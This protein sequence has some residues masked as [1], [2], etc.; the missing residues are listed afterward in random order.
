MKIFSPLTNWLNKSLKN[1]LLITTSLLILF[2]LLIQVILVFYISQKS[3]IQIIS[4]LNKVTAEQTALNL[5]GQLQNLKEDVDR[6]ALHI[7]D[8]CEKPEHFIQTMLDFLSADEDGVYGIYLYSDQGVQYYIDQNLLSQLKEVNVEEILAQ[9][10]IQPSPDVYFSYESA[11]KGEPQFI[12][13]DFSDSPRTPLISYS[14]PVF[15]ESGQQIYVLVVEFRINEIERV[16]KEIRVGENGMGYLIDQ[17]G[18]V[19]IHPDSDCVGKNI[20]ENLQP[21]F[22]SSDQIS[23]IVDPWTNFSKLAAYSPVEN[24]LGWVV[25]VEQPWLEAYSPVLE[26]ANISLIILFAALAILLLF[27]TQVEKYFSKPIKNLVSLTQEITKTGDLSKKLNVIRND[28][29]GQLASNFNQM[30]DSIQEIR[31]N[32]K[33]SEEKYRNIFENLPI[34]LWEE[35]FSDIKKYLDELTQKGVK[36]LQT[37]LKEHLDEAIFCASLVKVLNVNKATMYVYNIPY[38][39]ILTMELSEIFSDMDINVFIEEISSFYEGQTHFQSES[40][41][42]RSDGQILNALIDVVIPPGYEE[43][44]ERILVSI[45]DFTSR[46][47]A[48]ERLQES[49]T[50]YQNIFDYSPISLWEEDFSDIK[51]Y[52]NEL[53]EKGVKDLN[54]YFEKNPDEILYCA[55]LVKI[56]DVNQHSADL[57][58]MSRDELINSGFIGSLDEKSA[59]F[60]MDEILYFYGGGKLYRGET[61]FVTTEGEHNISITSVVLLPGSEDTWQKV[62]V[63]VQDI[64]DRRKMELSLRENEERFRSVVTSANDGIAIINENKE[65]IYWNPAAKAI[66]GFAREEANLK[67]FSKFMEEQKVLGVGNNLAQKRVNKIF[68]A[69]GEKKNG[70]PYLLELSINSWI[71]NEREYY[72]VVFRDIT[73]RKQQEDEK[74]TIQQISDLLLEAD[75]METVYKQFCVILV[76]RFQ[77]CFVSIELYD[78]IKNRFIS[79]ASESQLDD[80]SGLTSLPACVEML[81]EVSRTAN[82]LSITTTS[83]SCKKILDTYKVQKILLLPLQVRGHFL[84]VF[85]L[86]ISNLTHQESRLISMLRVL[87]NYLAQEIERKSAEEKLLASQKMA[88]LG[89][90]SAGIAH[91]MNSPLQIVTGLSDSISRKIKSGKLEEE[92]MLEYVENINQNAWRIAGIVRSLLTY[93]HTSDEKKIPENL[94]EIIQDTLLLIEH[95]VN[96]WDNV[97]IITDLHKNLPLFDLDRSGITQVLINLLMNARDAMPQGGVITISSDYDFKQ[98]VLILMIADTGMGISDA[99]QEKIFMPFFTTKPIGKGTGLGLSI[100]HGIIESHGGEIKVESRKGEGTTFTMIFHRNSQD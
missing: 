13:G 94:N 64:T 49:E 95:Q 28:E 72:S 84:G 57:L 48:E 76:E 83:K 40:A 44:W 24:E 89:T 7:Q 14:S 62:L 98:D 86:G 17:N 58:K 54:A 93:A 63:A 36:D 87:A 59:R 97:R 75:S 27:S 52:L 9:D 56:R 46:R 3:I 42:K 41:H 33:R 61:S 60:F 45:Q 90:L 96:K 15:D 80:F 10:K 99:H 91:E 23:E 43:N 81:E 92:K 73:E 21:L 20:Q 77:F 88:D 100:V 47:E 25:V 35:D 32:L 34:S 29:I 4:E 6:A 66:S 65:L 39:R 2:F 31:T 18:M 1:R 68:E 78:S 30:I 12:Q 79:T 69:W 82:S 85:S 74:E 22:N 67:I 8:A 51:N 11:L 16:V 38:E 55:G 26:F 53:V 71:S 50:H 5:N 19:I 37:Y 70:E